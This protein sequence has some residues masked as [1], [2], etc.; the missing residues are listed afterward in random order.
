MRPFF[1]FLIIFLFS[2]FKV[3]AEKLE[4]VNIYGNKR[5]SKDTIIVFT[6]LK[7][8]QNFNSENANQVIKNLY[9]TNFFKE[10]S[11]KINSGILDI[12]LEENPIIQNIFITGVKNKK[13]IK[14]IEDQFTIREKDL[15][16]NL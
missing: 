2:A 4:K 10:V 14:I 13:I 15:M 12:K 6:K 1:I 11:V 7:I 16:L 8:G 5:I 9:E 3:Y